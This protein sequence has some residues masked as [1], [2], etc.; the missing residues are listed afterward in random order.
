MAREKRRITIDAET[1]EKLEKICKSEMNGVS[2]EKIVDSLE[3]FAGR[4]KEENGVLYN[5]YD[6]IPSVTRF[7][8]LLN[9]DDPGSVLEANFMHFPHLL[10]LYLEHYRHIWDESFQPTG[11]LPPRSK[12]GFTDPT[13]KVLRK[14]AG[15]I[16]SFK[17]CGTSTSAPVMSDPKKFYDRGAPGLIWGVA[18]EHHRYDGRRKQRNDDIKNGI[19]LCIHHVTIVDQDLDITAE[20]LSEYKSTHEFLIRECSEGRKKITFSFNPN[21]RK[22]TEVAAIF[23]FTKEHPVFWQQYQHLPAAELASSVRE[24]LTFTGNFAGNNRFGS[25]LEHLLAGVEST[26]TA[27]V[28]IYNLHPLS[29]SLVHAGF[30]SFKKIIG[31]LLYEMSVY[32]E[33]ELPAELLSMVPSVKEIDR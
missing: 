24:L 6:H 1:K 27:L 18:P 13:I 26:S 33:V 19:W 11:V 30:S 9:L 29:E 4:L 7:K 3:N 8:H 10:Q 23:D 28:R 14:R 5:N 20:Q 32:Y 15:E 16:C 12:N 21:D 31:L 2:V 25:K 22:A 17:D